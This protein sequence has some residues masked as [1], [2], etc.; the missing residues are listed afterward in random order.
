MSNCYDKARELGN[1]ILESSPAKKL[2]EA[3]Q[4]FD[5]NAEAKK[6]LD[7]YSA[8]QMEFRSKAAQGE[9]TQDEFAANSEK[10][11]EM[12]EKLKSNE[13]I[14]NLMAAETEFNDFVNGVMNILKFTI[15]GTDASDAC[16][17]HG[18]AGGNCGGC[19]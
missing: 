14:N 13:V 15:T 3:R 11:M 8:F 18:C 16:G 12:A 6:G 5:A 2:N 10:L 17:C 7:E 9:I 4:A 19:D 1:L